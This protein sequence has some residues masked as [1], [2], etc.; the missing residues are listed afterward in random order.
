MFLCWYTREGVELPSLER[1]IVPPRVLDQDQVAEAQGAEGQNGPQN[2]PESPSTSNQDEPRAEGGEQATANG[3]QESSQVTPADQSGSADE[4]TGGSIP[5]GQDDG[6]SAE[7]AQRSNEA[8]SGDDSGQGAAEQEP[9]S[10][11]Q[12]AEGQEAE[13]QGSGDQ[14]SPAEG[15]RGAAS[16][17]TEWTWAKINQMWRKFNIDLA[18]KVGIYFFYL[19]GQLSRKLQGLSWPSG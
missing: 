6:Q 19:S 13:G 17:T 10:Q 11:G 2:S 9:G 5:Q 14:R 1:V 15:Q 7:Q 4:A 12:E 16:N 8:A 3:D 18:P